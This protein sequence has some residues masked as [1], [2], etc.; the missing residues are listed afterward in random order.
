MDESNVSTN[1]PNA[2]EV[3]NWATAADKH[4]VKAA[5]FIFQGKCSSSSGASRTCELLLDLIAGARTP[6]KRL[7]RVVQ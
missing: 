2:Q 3:D 7:G 4:L 5:D 6:L 1:P